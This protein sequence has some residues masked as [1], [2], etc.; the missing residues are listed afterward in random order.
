MAEEALQGA[1]AAV[2]A[3]EWP[4]Y[5]DLEWA[6]L[7]QSMRRP[8]IVDGRRLLPETEL[9]ALGYV[10]ERVGDGVDG[11]LESASAPLN[12]ASTGRP[13]R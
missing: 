9:R 6:A 2:I 3:T 13:A 11:D 5:R 8:L 7:R 12:E 10:V 4:L 1:D